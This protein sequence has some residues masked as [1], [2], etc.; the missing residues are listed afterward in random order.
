MITVTMGARMIKSLLSK[1]SDEFP[2]FLIVS[3]PLLSLFFAMV[4]RVLN[5]DKA[6]SAPVMILGEGA[7]ASIPL[8]YR[9]S[10]SQ[11]SS[12]ITIVKSGGGAL[13]YEINA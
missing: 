1:P 4:P 12:A 2:D 8:L 11:L 7:T 9:T 10:K 13:L 6:P 3:N 5:L